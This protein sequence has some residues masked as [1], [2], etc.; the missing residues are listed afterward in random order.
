[1]IIKKQ[2]GLEIKQ[3]VNSVVNG[4]ATIKNTKKIIVLFGIIILVFILIRVLFAGD[5]FQNPEDRTSGLEAHYFEADNK[6][7]IDWEYN[8]ETGASISDQYID[9]NYYSIYYSQPINKYVI[10][11]K[12]GYKLNRSDIEEWILDNIKGYTEFAGGVDL[13]KIQF[14]DERQYYAGEKDE[15]NLEPFIEKKPEIENYDAE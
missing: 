12:A 8:I 2:S 1:M 11:I 4:L 3:R 15:S 5:R 7:N 14:F 10:T 9:N 13:N 6:D